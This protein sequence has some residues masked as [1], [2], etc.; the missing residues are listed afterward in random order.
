MSLS[1][2]TD[3]KSP[4]PVIGGGLRSVRSLISDL[5]SNSSSVRCAAA[6]ALGQTRDSRAL[7]PLVEALSHYDKNTKIAAAEAL[8]ALGDPR[9]IDPLAT[10]MRRESFET[11]EAI[12]AALE[13][14]GASKTAS[15]E[16]AKRTL[17][18]GVTMV[19]R[20]GVL[21][22]LIGGILCAY[23]IVAAIVN[24]LAANPESA[25]T[26]PSGIIVVG[27][28]IFLRGVYDYLK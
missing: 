15:V 12:K 14:L 21:R 23:G 13:K 9:A 3:K 10:A 24:Y 4:A 25:L 27:V 6:R 5:D 8:G 18:D 20:P 11:Y 2:E 17:R 28:A 22:M 1:I 26:L 7:E 19:G 16:Q